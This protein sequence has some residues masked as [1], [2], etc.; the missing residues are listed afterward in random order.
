ML[1]NSLSEDDL[2]M[3]HVVHLGTWTFTS[4]SILNWI[5]LQG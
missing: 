3:F 2:A 5:E 4:V 1:F